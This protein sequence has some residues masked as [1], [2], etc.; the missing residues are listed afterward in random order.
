[1]ARQ[2]HYGSKLVRI[3]RIHDEV[4]KAVDEACNEWAGKGYRL[5]KANLITGEEG[6]QGLLLIFE[7][8]MT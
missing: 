4:Q 7:R 6:T 2:Y 8:D 3:L 1:M 5:T